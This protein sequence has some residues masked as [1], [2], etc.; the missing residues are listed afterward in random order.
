MGYYSNRYRRG[1][2]SYGVGGLGSVLLCIA[3]GVFAIFAGSAAIAML[4]AGLCLLVIY[5]MTAEA[6][7]NKPEPKLGWG[8]NGSV[9]TEESD[10]YKREVAEGRTPKPFTYSNFK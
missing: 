1:S 10:W 7:S 3:G 5:L 6:C 9:P 8:K 4:P 2:R